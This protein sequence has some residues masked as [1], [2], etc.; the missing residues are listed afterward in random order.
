VIA[1]GIWR[2]RIIDS[3]RGANGFGYDPLFLYPPLGKT[4][5]ELP[6]DQ[7]HA[8]SHRGKALARLKELISRLPAGWMKEN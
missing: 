4:T 1:D 5:A 3:P 6:P 8:I 2:G 7:K